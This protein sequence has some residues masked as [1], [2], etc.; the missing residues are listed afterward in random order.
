MKIKLTQL[1][2]KVLAG[3]QRLGY[4]GEDAK[5][6]SDTLLYAQLRG[7]NQGIA[8]L[9]TGGVPPAN[10]IE[11]FT[12]VKEN[13]SGALFSGGHSMVAR[14]RRKQLSLRLSMALV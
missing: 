11:P 5:I 7:N 14:L 1:T 12:L 13:K 8:K 9:A 10:E 4:N 2:D 3:V 6:I